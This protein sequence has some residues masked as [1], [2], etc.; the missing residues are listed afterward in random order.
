MFVHP[1]GLVSIWV[2]TT[3]TCLLNTQVSK[4]IERGGGL[5]QYSTPSPP[6]LPLSH[7]PSLPAPLPTYLHSNSSSLSVSPAC[8]ML[9]LTNWEACCM[10]VFLSEWPRSTN[11][12]CQHTAQASTW[13][14]GLW[15]LHFKCTNVCVSVLCVWLLCVCVRMCAFINILYEIHTS[16]SKRWHRSTFQHK[17]ERVERSAVIGEMS[18]WSRRGDGAAETKGR[19]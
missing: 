11:P 4:F 16:L 2:Y 14:S 3:C 9:R 18:M 6:S 7:F 15:C 17:S 5:D 1:F 8:M 12:S 10:V 19:K 13:I